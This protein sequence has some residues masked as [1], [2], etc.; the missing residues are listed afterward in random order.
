MVK[1]KNKK[2]GGFKMSKGKVKKFFIT[3]IAFATLGLLGVVPNLEAGTITDSNATTLSTF[4]VAKEVVEAGTSENPVEVNVGNKIT[5]IDYKP[6]DIPLGALSDPTVS[7]KLSAGKW[8]VNNTNL[9]VCSR[10]G[11]VIAEYEGGNETHT[12]VFSGSGTTLANDVKYYIGYNNGT[13]NCTALPPDALGLTVPPGTST[14]T[15]TV[16]AGT[17]ATQVIHDTASGTLIEVK[18]QYSA[19]V[20]KELDAEIDYEEDFKKLY[21]EGRSTENDNGTVTIKYENLNWGVNNTTTDDNEIVTVVLEPSDISGI[22]KVQIDPDF[23][24]NYTTNCT[25][26]EDNQKFTCTY[27][28]TD[29]TG[30]KEATLKVIVDG[31]TVLA[32]RD[33][34]VDVSLDFKD[35][36][37]KDENLLVDEDFGA[38]TYRGTAI[39]VPLIGVDPSTGR[40]TYIKL[41]SKDTSPNAN[42]V[43][44]IILASDGTLV[45]ADIGQITAGQPF[46]I[47]G[48]D[49][50]AKVEAA[51]KSVEDSFAAILVVTTSEENLFGYANII[52][53]NGAKR[54]PLKVKDGEIVE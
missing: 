49:L 51:G 23:G 30:N 47:T 3:G 19:E 41:Q 35:D 10:D 39:Y 46:V 1:E 26:D 33:F 32:E 18:P 22:S 24:S 14:I 53:P 34:K 2:E 54:V 43:R 5:G 28:A 17:A 29:I 40:E 9:Q 25:K 20:S 42:K 15:L 6:T 27:N 44:A 7:F 12:L 16:N 52:D 48:S 13:N 45:T 50:K 21:D 38:W 36:E 4:T 37:A 11:E 8:I 31:T